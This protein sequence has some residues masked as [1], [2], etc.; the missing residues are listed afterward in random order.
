MQSSIRRRSGAINLG[1]PAPFTQ[2]SATSSYS[3]QDLAAYSEDNP[4]LPTVTLV[5]PDAPRGESYISLNNDGIALVSNDGQCSLGALG[6]SSRGE[7]RT[8]LGKANTILPLESVRLSRPVPLSA[9]SGHSSTASLS[10]VSSL[11]YNHFPVAGTKLTAKFPIS[12]TVKKLAVEFSDDTSDLG[13]ETCDRW[14]IHKW[15]L[16]FSVLSLLCY[17]TAGLAYAVL[18]WF[19][20]W[21]QAEVMSVANYDILVLITLASSII[22]LTFAIGVTGTILNSRPILAVYS[23]LLWPALISILA[24][25]YTAYKRFAFSLDRKLNLAWSQWYT[26]DGRLIIQNS[27]Q[28]CGYYSPL[29]EAAASARCYIRSSLPGCKSK[30]LRFER[31]NLQSVWTVAFSI[32]PVHIVNIFVSLLCSNHVNRTF[33]KGIVPRQYRLRGADVQANAAKILATVRQTSTVVRPAPARSSA[34][35]VPREDKVD[36]RR[37]CDIVPASLRPGYGPLPH[38][39]E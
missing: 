38:K 11:K 14:S 2:C 31:M 8:S 23:L 17:G 20:S 19:Q 4:G 6:F 5:T 22:L 16:L 26:P 34:S 27:L 12:T 3:I 25:G 13:I 28:C 35:G 15:C 1:H 9:S 18:T 30:L 33:G 37:V 24:I 7:R 10:S 36:A 32:V 39:I 29:H 21:E